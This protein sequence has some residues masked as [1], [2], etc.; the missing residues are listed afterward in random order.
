MTSDTTLTHVA[1]MF[2]HDFG[3]RPVHIVD[4]DQP[5]TITGEAG[6]HWT[7]SG[8]TQVTYP[9]A[10]QRAGGFSVYHPSTIVTEVG[11]GWAKKFKGVRKVDVLLHGTAY[12]IIGSRVKFAGYIYHKALHSRLGRI[13]TRT[14]NGVTAVDSYS[15]NGHPDFKYGFRGEE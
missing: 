15:A 11:E 4:G 14:A 13:I 12:E 6:S 3:N 2:A 8:K 10:Y 9:N 5:P 1:R 7:E